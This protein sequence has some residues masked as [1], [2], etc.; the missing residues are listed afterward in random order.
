MGAETSTDIVIRIQIGYEPITETNPGLYS[1]DS[2]VR[3][4]PAA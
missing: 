3:V 4:G 2:I 1:I